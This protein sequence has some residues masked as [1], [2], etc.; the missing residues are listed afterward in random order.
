M[1]ARSL[2]CTLSSM[3]P[4]Q[5]GE[6]TPGVGCSPLTCMCAQL[7]PT[8]SDPLDYSSS[9]PGIQYLLI[10]GC[11]FL[12][13]GLFR[14]QGSNP[15]LLHWQVD[16]LPQNCPGWDKSYNLLRQHLVGLAGAGNRTLLKETLIL[17]SPP[18]KVG[19]LEFAII[20]NLKK[21]KI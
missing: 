8:L 21:L 5:G 11:Y 6:S 14:T 12:H 17:S 18:D 20:Q 15:C 7:C 1:H 16:S 9:V 10:V 2:C 13:L 3:S 19:Q 4:H